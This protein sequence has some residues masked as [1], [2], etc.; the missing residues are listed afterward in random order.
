[1][2]TLG[3][4][5]GEFTLPDALPE[6][7]LFLTAGSGITP[8]M[9]M[10]RWLHGR[11]AMPDSVHVHCAR[12]AEEAIFAAELE[13]MCATHEHYR[14][15]QRATAAEGRIGPEHLD[16][17]CSDWREREA[18]A[19]GPGAMLDALRS[20]YSRAQ[21]SE[22]LHVESF[23]HMLAGE[24]VGMGGEVSFTRSR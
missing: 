7:L 8:V 10:L 19:C 5:E 17:L 4:V 1:I 23:E 16:E 15:A 9:A 13:R 3:E 12:S 6:K 18:Y 11:G 22:R 20:H 14:L 24:F 2:V 21:L